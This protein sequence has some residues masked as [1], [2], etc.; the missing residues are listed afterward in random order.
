MPLKTTTR[1][2]TLFLVVAALTLLLD[3]STKAIVRTYLQLSESIPLLEGI[4][5][6][7]YLKNPGAAF[8][9][10]PGAL[11]LFT[12]T[13]VIVIVG[14]IIFWI[15]ARPTSAWAIVGLGLFTAGATGNFIDRV[16]AGK[17]TDFLDVTLINAPIFNVAD[18]G[19]SIGIFMLVLWMFL[20]TPQAHAE[21]DSG[22]GSTRVDLGA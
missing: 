13:F 14:S 11:P 1:P 9:L 20:D 6:L 7:T 3:Q 12:A 8:G 22:E 17:V 2:T 19:I 16:T 18:V 4:F 15:K 10:F 5:H 21:R